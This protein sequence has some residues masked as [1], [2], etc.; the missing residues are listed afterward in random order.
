MWLVRFAVRLLT[1][2]E[3]ERAAQPLRPRVGLAVVDGRLVLADTSSAWAASRPTGFSTST[4]LPAS[5]ASRAFA[6]WAWCG[7]AT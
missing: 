2:R 4:C 5:M 1:R 6:W 7:V 3:E